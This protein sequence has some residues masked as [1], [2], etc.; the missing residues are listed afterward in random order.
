MT[1]W[2]P[3][4]KSAQ[5]IAVEM[6]DYSK[7][8]SKRRRGWANEKCRGKVA[9]KSLELQSDDARPPMKDL[10]ASAKA[11]ASSIP[12]WRNGLQALRKHVNKAVG[13]NNRARL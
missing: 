13:E 8:A 9:R 11:T 4:S 10:V 6:E 7:K 12:I 3:V 5:A 2:S 1:S